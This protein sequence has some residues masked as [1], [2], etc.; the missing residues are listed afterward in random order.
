MLLAAAA[1]LLVIVVVVVVLAA[2]HGK[3]GGSRINASEGNFFFID[4]WGGS[5]DATG[6]R[7]GRASGMSG[8]AG[9]LW[10]KHGHRRACF[11]W[12]IV[13]ATSVRELFLALG[14][15]AHNNKH[16]VPF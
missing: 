10:R 3:A 9:E 13:S 6:Q 12:S 2:G 11:L 16:A 5:G 4:D 1:F 7:G 8:L 14:G 15:L